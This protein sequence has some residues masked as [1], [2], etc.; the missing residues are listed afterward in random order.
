MRTR[1]RIAQDPATPLFE[2]V[3][4]PHRLVTELDAHGAIDRHATMC[5][6]NAIEDALSAGAE[7]VVVDLR[8]L[9]SIDTRA[10]ALFGWARTACH[11]C[12]AQLGLLISGAPRHYA[13][14]AAFNESGLGEQLRFA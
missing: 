8:D 10:L 4:R 7:M 13:I 2:A 12:D 14:A 3:T 5:L 1:T 11:G 9:V 6:K